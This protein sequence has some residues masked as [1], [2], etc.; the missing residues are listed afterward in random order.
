LILTKGTYSAIDKNTNLLVLHEAG[1]RFSILEEGNDIPY[2]YSSKGAMNSFTVEPIADVLGMGKSILVSSIPSA[3]PK[4]LLRITVYSE[5]GFIAM[6]A[7]VEN[8]LSHILQ[9]K[10]FSPLD[11]AIFFKGADLRTNFSLLNGNGGGSNTFVSHRENNNPSLNNVM[12]TFGKEGHNRSLV[13]GGLSYLEFEKYAGIDI[14]QDF[15]KAQ[16]YAKDPIG[17][18]I[19]PGTRYL[20][21]EDRFY[22][23][24]MTD[25]PFE[26]LETYANYLRIAQGVVLPVCHFPIVDTWFAQVPHFGG[27]SRDTTQ[28]RAQNDSFGAVE[29]MECVVRSGFLK[30]S[31]VAVLLEPDLYGPINQQGWWDDEHWQRGPGN[32]ARK[33]PNWISSNGQ[34]VPPLRR[35]ANGRE[36]LKQWGE[37][38]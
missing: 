18:R 10:E 25:N 31:P 7:G 32:R 38:R 13:I 9:L 3:G 21:T 11:S 19:D 14:K 4:L 5:F 6:A 23:D 20:V 15:L 37:Y 2:D 35:P 24:F 17:K 34:F 12:V 1:T 33:A 27:G 16:T 8:T 26:A 30:Y 29:E 22:I 28:Y 36:L